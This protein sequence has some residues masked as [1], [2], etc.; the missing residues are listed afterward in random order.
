MNV[1]RGE[2]I[3]DFESLYAAVLAD[4]DSWIITEFFFYVVFYNCFCFEH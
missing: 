2:K 1:N 4:F 3:D